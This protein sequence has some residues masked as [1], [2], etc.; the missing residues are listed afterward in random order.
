M[1]SNRDTSTSR[2]DQSEHGWDVLHC[3]INT[4]RRGETALLDALQM[5]THRKPLILDLHIRDYISNRNISIPYRLYSIYFVDKNSASALRPFYTWC[6]STACAL[7]CCAQRNAMQCNTVFE[8]GD[9]ACAGAHS[10]TRSVTYFHQANRSKCGISRLITPAK[11]WPN[12]SCGNGALIVAEIVFARLQ[13]ILE[14]NE[15]AE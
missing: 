8:Y 15:S 6:A 5:H 1:P 7:Q 12:M 2:R 14:A 10:C 11:S 3:T 9:G 4:R 13:A